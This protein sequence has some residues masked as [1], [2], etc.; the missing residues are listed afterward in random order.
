MKFAFLSD[1]HAVC[2]LPKITRRVLVWC[3]QEIRAV[4]PDAVILGGD[5]THHPRAGEADAVLEEL[6]LR[7]FSLIFLPGNNETLTLAPE[8]SPAGKLLLRDPVTQYAEAIFFLAAS[9][10][11]EF[12][13]AV[14]KLLPQ[15]RAGIS[16]LVFA[17]FPPDMATEGQ[18][19]RL[20]SGPHVDWICGHRHQCIQRDTGSLRVWISPGLDAVKTRG[21][22][23]GLFV[24]VW[25]A[26]GVRVHHEEAPPACLCPAPERLQNLR[27]GLAF[28]GS[29]SEILETALVHRIPAAQFHHSCSQGTPTAR[30][31]AL[32]VR[33]REAVPESFLSLHLPDFSHPEEG[34]DMAEFEPWLEWAEG[35]GL[36]NLTVHFPE[37]AAD[38]LFTENG[39]IASTAWSARCLDAYE[40]LARRA[41]ALGARLSLENHHNET[42][43]AAP[44]Q[45]RLGS[46]P[47]H[48]IALVRRIRETLESEGISSM[49]DARVGLLFDPGHAI[50][51]PLVSKQHGL[52]DWLERL[53][54]SLHLLHIHQ[55]AAVADN[56]GRHHRPI[57]DIFGPYINYA[58]LLPV[59][60]DLTPRPL[61]LLIEVSDRKQALQSWCTLHDFL[62]GQIG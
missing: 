50:T 57:R 53:A 42:R 19:R 61:P 27:T 59:L 10:E 25:S 13:V 58:G 46:R 41:L 24:V 35:M 5:L 43:P 48:L 7:E 2:P 44:G 33:Y 28:L 54:P 23:P 20:A 34:P 40:R 49:D 47:D 45:E 32:V 11:T 38:F 21:G 60:A 12:A 29:A 39:Q 62:A 22:R 15:L 18:L 31:R 36:D 51:D 16:N 14:E 56:T 55:V 6:A 30:E 17:H 1:V 4:A 52:A 3:A 26:E 9:T 37:V 8:D